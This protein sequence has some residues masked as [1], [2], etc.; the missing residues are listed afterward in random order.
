MK[1]FFQ[2]VDLKYYYALTTRGRSKKRSTTSSRPWNFFYRGNSSSFSRPR[3][4]SEQYEIVY[5]L[6]QFRQHVRH[7]YVKSSLRRM[8]PIASRDGRTQNVAKSGEVQEGCLAA[9]S[10]LWLGFAVFD[11]NFLG[12]FLEAKIQHLVPGT[13]V[14]N[15]QYALTL[16]TFNASAAVTTTTTA[17]CLRFFPGNP[18]IEHYQLVNS[19]RLIVGDLQTVKYSQPPHTPIS[20]TAASTATRHSSI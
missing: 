5:D 3:A 6:V 20:F 10:A 15:L 16:L 11:T 8:F 4:R 9:C 13:M 19:R 2:P 17:I 14:C 1:T 18:N 7:V 12:F